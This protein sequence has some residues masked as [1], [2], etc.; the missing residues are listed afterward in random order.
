LG[1]RLRCSEILANDYVIV[2]TRLN[3][4]SNGNPLGRVNLYLGIAS[5]AL[6]QAAEYTRN[7]TRPWL[8]SGVNRAVD[9]PYIAERYGV[10]IA[11]LS[12]SI[13]LA[14]QAGGKVQAALDRGDLLS[15]DER[16][17][18]AIEVAKAKV[19]GKATALSNTAKIFEVYLVFR[20]CGDPMLAFALFAE[21]QIF[22]E[23]TA[24]NNGLQ[25]TYRI[26]AGTRVNYSKAWLRQLALSF[27]FVSFQSYL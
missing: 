15:A 17:E 24:E 7:I 13:A 11:D 22:V 27:R 4:K 3:F 19:H 21:K 10:L 6:E 14:D 20:S 16:A 5:G 18:V 23:K 26:R 1:I 8:F 25:N 9:D 2:Y 12:A